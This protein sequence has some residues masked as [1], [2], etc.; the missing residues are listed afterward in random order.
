MLRRVDVDVRYAGA[1]G[2]D[3]RLRLTLELRDVGRP[4]P[5]G[6]PAHDRPIGDLDAAV[7][8]LAS[9]LQRRKAADRA[10]GAT[11][12]YER[13]LADAAGD[14]AAGAGVLR[15]RRPVAP[16]PPVVP[17]DGP[18]AGRGPGG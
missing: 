17:P 5:I 9:A 8:Q 4:Q 16:A 11:N 2:R 3:G 15:A 14:L 13:C 18:G 6:P 10:S 1:A 7:R 12:A